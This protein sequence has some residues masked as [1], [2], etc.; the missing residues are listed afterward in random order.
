MKLFKHTVI[1]L[2]ACMGLTPAAHAQWLRLF[3]QATLKEAAPLAAS[4]ARHSIAPILQNAAFSQASK[5]LAQTNFAKDILR[6]NPEYSVYMEQID[7]AQRVYRYIDFLNGTENSLSVEIVQKL[8]DLLNRVTLMS[9]VIRQV[10]ISKLQAPILSAE[11][12]PVLLKQMG[13]YFGFDTNRSV[14]VL[15]KQGR[16][17]DDPLVALSRDLYKDFATRLENFVKENKRMPRQLAGLSSEAEMALAREYQL[18]QFVART[19]NLAPIR[20]YIEKI[21]KIVQSVQ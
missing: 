5:T 4:S 11:K 20:P 2:V 12:Y 6:Q 7:Y 13:E 15:A 1:I 17:Q 3:P 10:W 18:L 8:T 9:P 21:D 19:N 14:E 16:L